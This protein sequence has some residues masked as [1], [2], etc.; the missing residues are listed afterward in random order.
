LFFGF[1]L[2]IVFLGIVITVAYLGITGINDSE[3]K[4]FQRDFAVITNL[5]ELRA[6][7]NRQR[8]DIEQMMFW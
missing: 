5:L 6:D 3:Q 8:A 7:P 4:L 1:G 2:V